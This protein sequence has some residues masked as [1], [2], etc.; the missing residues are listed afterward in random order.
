MPP[1]M[2]LIPKKGFG[3]TSGKASEKLPPCGMRRRVH[4]L[5]ETGEC[6]S[7]SACPSPSSGPVVG[8]P[9]TR[10]RCLLSPG[11]EGAMGPRRIDSSLV[12][13][14][15][16]C[17]GLQGCGFMP[18][19]HAPQAKG[20]IPGYFPS[21]PVGWGVQARHLQRPCSGQAHGSPSPR[22]RPRGCS[23]VED[24]IPGFGHDGVG[25][26]QERRTSQGAEVMVSESSVV[27]SSVVCS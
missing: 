3:P 26:T 9:Y 10:E 11:D 22:P 12:S 24:R 25:A 2:T 16:S 5:E 18:P 14:M 1:L 20:S 23:G 17:P 19:L 21:S 27:P 7:C 4:F 13:K 8:P 15:V 6:H